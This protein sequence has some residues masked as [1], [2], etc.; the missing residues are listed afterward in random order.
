[1]I[2][3]TAVMIATQTGVFLSLACCGGFVGIRFVAPFAPRRVAIQ[4]GSSAAKDR[5]RGAS[6]KIATDTVYSKM[7]IQ[8][9]QYVAKKLA[10]FSGLYP[11]RS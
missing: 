7:K 6:E 11:R 9:N 4:P 2:A 3:P 10:A 5:L 8:K 1:M